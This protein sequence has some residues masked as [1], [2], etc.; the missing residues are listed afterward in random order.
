[1]NPSITPLGDS[2][3]T[4][5]FG[6]TIDPEINA[7]VLSAFHQL[8]EKSIPFIKDLVPA[9]ASLSVLYDVAAI[10]HR[11]HTSS[12]FNFMKEKLETVLESFTESV[13]VSTRTI[14]IPVCY[15]VSLAQDLESL[16]RQKALSTDELIRIHT[17]TTYRVYMLGFLPG[18]P[19][20]GTVPE[21]IA[22]PR[23]T[24]PALRIPAGS[25]GIAGLQTGI[26]PFE[27]PGGWNIIG[28][29]PINM[30]DTNREQPTYLQPGDEV[31]F[32]PI[33]LDEWNEQNPRYQE[34]YI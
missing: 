21:Q 16:A 30:F 11:A 20:M 23:K 33:T 28:R 27:S 6:N 8:K 15:D 3:L 5:S 34:S 13:P 32:I 9:Y 29:T 24:Q 17:G 26:Y 12:A 2:A 18:F 1:M 7:R 31:K 4:I 14:T 10:R 22:A 25:I 19:Y